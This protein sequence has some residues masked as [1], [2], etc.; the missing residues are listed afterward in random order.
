[1]D[2]FI[3]INCLPRY[4]PFYKISNLV[5]KENAALLFVSIS[6][7]PALQFFIIIMRRVASIIR[8]SP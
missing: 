5:F 1:M 7:L 2:L 8:L 4:C 6:P 3:K